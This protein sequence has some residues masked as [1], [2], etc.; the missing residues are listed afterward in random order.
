MKKFPVLLILIFLIALGFNLFIGKAQRLPPDLPEPCV[1]VG[2]PPC[3]PENPPPAPPVASVV[4]EA[5]NSPITVNPP[6]WAAEKE[7]FRTR[8]VPRTVLIARLFG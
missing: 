8:I 7:F 2:V 1:P 4:F 6:L 5:I 3:P